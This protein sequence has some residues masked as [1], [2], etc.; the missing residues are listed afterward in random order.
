MPDSFNQPPPA[1]PERSLETEVEKAKHLLRMLFELGEH[2]AEEMVEEGIVNLERR[3]YVKG[4]L[5]QIY[6]DLQT[7]NKTNQD[8]YTK[9]WIWNKEGDLTETEFDELNLRRKKLSNAVGIMTAGGLRH[10]INEI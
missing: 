2:Y 6:K 7:L 3:E 4:L 1:A 10:D 8:D 5:P 9:T